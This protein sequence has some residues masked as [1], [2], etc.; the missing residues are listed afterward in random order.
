[1]NIETFVGLRFL[2]PKRRQILISAI[3]MI[4]V[5][6]V[7]VGVAALI[8]VISVLTGFQEVVQ[9][10]HLEAFSHLIIN[11]FQ[12]FI[13]DQN[14]FME[15][16]AAHSEVEAVSP[17]ILGEVMLASESGV[18]GAVIRGVMAD[19]V[20]NVTSLK[21]N[22][23]MGQLDS[24]NISH[25]S[26][27]SSN[28]DKDGKTIS[29]EYPG[30]LLGDELAAQLHVV[31]GSEIR[32]ISPLGETTPMGVVPKMRRFV[33]S[34]IFSTGLYTFD[35]QF[36]FI[37]LRQAQIFFNFPEDGI[38]G[39]ECRLKDLWKARETGKEISAQL[40]WPYK[41]ISWME[42]NRNL[43]SAMKLEKVVMFIIVSLISMVAAFNIFSTI[44]MMV[45]DKQKSI[46]ILKTMGASNGR[47]T[48]MFIMPGVIIALLGSLLGFC[49]G[50]GLCLL[51]LKFGL[52]KLDPQVYMFE[53]LPMKFKLL[54]FTII[55][56]A[57][58]G[59]SL[60]A[61][62]IPARIAAKLDP[63]KVLRYE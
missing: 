37:S 5:T 45:M 20:G 42:L 23:E 41:S 35:A 27:Y 1:M 54:D 49:L 40:G 10:K 50:I 62:I 13:K 59:F 7:A 39:V 15:K 2:K 11:S 58:F 14:Q 17:F 34:G 12:P 9:S 19:K 4:T 8:I 24:I 6:G 44:Y 38:S 3:T 28:E 60:I 57:A 16:V 51:Q 26:P 30:I 61:T 52:V 43:F 22:M 33:V 46:A 31:I 29:V 32:V 48:R 53:Q 25:P 55:A 63:V 21:D 47:I 56:V 18:S 36:A